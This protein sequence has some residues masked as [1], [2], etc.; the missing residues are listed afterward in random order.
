[1]SAIQSLGRNWAIDSRLYKTSSATP[2]VASKQLTISVPDAAE[3]AQTLADNLSK[4]K[5]YIQKLQQVADSLD[6]KVTFNVNQE[7]GQVVVKIVD[8][9]TDK[10]IREIPSVDMQELKVTMRQTIGMI[11]DESV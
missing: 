8:P 1:M 4:D 2:S 3:V 6:R 5:T 9:S 10:I 11:I 7:L